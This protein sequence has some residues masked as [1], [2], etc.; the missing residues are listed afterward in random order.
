V[1]MQPPVYA[2]DDPDVRYR[3]V[4]LTN[5]QRAEQVGDRDRRFCE[6]RDSIAAKVGRF[7]LHHGSI[8]AAQLAAPAV[9]GKLVS[10]FQPGH[11]KLPSLVVGQSDAER[12]LWAAKVIWV[13]PPPRDHSIPYV[14][15]VRAKAKKVDS[16]RPGAAPHSILHHNVSISHSYQSYEP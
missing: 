1:Q 14:S 12:G 15:P 5:N 8:A 6:Q 4:F 16:H 3:R 11:T 10:T 13:K 9:L 2:A 7:V